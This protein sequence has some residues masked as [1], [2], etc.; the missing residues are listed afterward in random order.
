MFFTRFMFYVIHQSKVISVECNWDPY[1]RTLSNRICVIIQKLK[2]DNEIIILPVN[3]VY[4]FKSCIIFRFC[5]YVKSILQSCKV[6]VY[7]FAKD[8]YFLTRAINCARTYCVLKHEM[9]IWFR[10]TII[11]CARKIN[12][13]W[14]ILYLKNPHKSFFL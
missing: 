11:V 7:L 8:F 3:D 5:W 2:N 6:I 1:N 12:W 9:K 4:I 13:Q 14:N 10:E